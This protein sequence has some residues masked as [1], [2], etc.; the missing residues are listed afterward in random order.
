MRLE[1]YITHG[2]YLDTIEL[3]YRVKKIYGINTYFLFKKMCMVAAC[4]AGTVE[5]D[6]GFT[7]YI[8]Y[9]MF[10]SKCSH[11]IFHMLDIGTLFNIRMKYEISEKFF[12][13]PV[14]Y[15][16]NFNVL[17]LDEF[18]TNPTNFANLK[19]KKALEMLGN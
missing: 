17:E 1:N 3:A 11:H 16:Y 18:L 9:N 8:T 2:E 15:I 19:L 7:S 13:V 6:G 5:T 10:L 4:K 14:K 12:G